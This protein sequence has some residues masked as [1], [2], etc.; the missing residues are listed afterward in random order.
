MPAGPTYEPIA[1]NT[2]GSA[3]SSVTFSS[4]SGAYT[5]LIL[6]INGGTTTNNQFRLNV[7]N[8]SIDTGANYG[9]TQLY[10]YSSTIGSGRE[11]NATNPYVGV[12][13]STNSTHIIQFMNYANTTTYK[14][15]LNKGGD[16][17]QSQYDLSV[18]TWRST[19]AI[20]IIQINTNGGN[21]AS[22]TTLT[23]YGIASA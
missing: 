13:S 14:T 4:I 17:G 7:G 21:I 9:D 5:D 8:G 6:V 2:L 19:S 22:G 18:C 3:A 1:T 20:N 23:L 16:L 15:W 12:A 10:G 11:T